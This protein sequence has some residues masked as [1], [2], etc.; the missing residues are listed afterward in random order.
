MF[1]VK[2]QRI[3][4]GTVKFEEA[5]KLMREGKSV[6][7]PH[8]IDVSISR[9]TD[10]EWGIQM[11]DILATDWM[12]ASELNSDDPAEENSGEPVNLGMYDP[13]G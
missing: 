7:R 2:H 5:L 10:P 13:N 4:T 1:P 12:D 9:T 8:W 6:T 3:R 11:K